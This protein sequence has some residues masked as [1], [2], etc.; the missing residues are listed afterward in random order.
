MRQMHQYLDRPEYLQHFRLGNP[1]TETCL[2]EYSRVGDTDIPLAA[3]FESRV[4]DF[5][6]DLFSPYTTSVIGVIRL[7]LEP[8]SAETP[9]TMLK[10]N[11][12]MH[13]IVG[14]PEREG[15]NVHAQLFLS[16][17]SEEG[18]ATTTQMIKDF[19]EGA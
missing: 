18:G 15:T 3:V 5:T 12:V 6:L 17:I 1:F 7:S 9:P 10:F 11:V 2:P 14:F 4:Q 16:G 19:D 13:D 8:S